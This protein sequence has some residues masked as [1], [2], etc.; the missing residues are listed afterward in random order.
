[1]CP[2][3]VIALALSF[4]CVFYAISTFPQEPAADELTLRVNAAFEA[5]KS[6]DA[7]AVS[8]ASRPVIA[9]TL[10]RMAKLRLD[11]KAYEEATKL[12]RDSLEFEDTALT[13]MEMAIASLYAKKPAEAVE[14]ATIATQM[15][16]RNA[17][18]WSIKGQA[19]LRKSDFEGASVALKTA[20]DLKRDSETLHALGIAYL[21]MREKE[22][23][24]ETFSQVLV[25]TGDAGWSRVLIGRAYQERKFPQDAV[26]QFKTALQLDPR[27]PN[28]HY[29]WAF[30]LLQAND[31]SPTPE[32]QAQL[33]EELHLNS[34]H[35]LA[36]YVLG[37]SESMERK[38]AESDR[39]LR[40][41]L[42]LSP[43]LPEIW[44]YLGLNAN[45]REER[46]SAERYFR[47]AISLREHDAHPGQ[48]LSVRKAYIVLGR[49]LLTTGRENEGNQLLQ[50]AR[51]MQL[52]DLTDRQEKV[53]TIKSKEGTGVSGAV[54]PDIS[55]AENQA[56]LSFAPASNQK[57][58]AS[59]AAAEKAEAQL[60]SLLGSSFNDLA[61][62]EALQEEFALALKHYLAA[63]TWD[64]H[65]PGL[66]RNLGLAYFATNDFAKSAKALAPFAGRAGQDPQLGFALA[67]SFA[68]TGNKLGAISVLQKMEATET[69]P[70]ALRSVEIGKLWQKLNQQD[71]AAKSFRRALVIDPRNAEANCA[72][73]L[74]A[75]SSAAQ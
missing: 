24:H 71:R 44:M 17:L 69:S 73:H 34:R 63:S 27:T 26:E 7:I 28:A 40:V 46:Q 67:K 23:A 3:F 32:V 50:K 25:L 66:Q 1:M 31:W 41:A 75:C 68:E 59:G 35:F 37:I 47:K 30:T 21:G 13:R 38:F 11:A 43:S 14:Q 49:I 72:L 39:Y 2:K 8:Q 65:I 60:R 6:E 53:A 4:F 55:E 5:R 48:H 70:D 33:L 54:V 36:N 52:E 45:A 9:L 62:A 42:E 58:H 56:P 10:V 29:Y 18:T 16:P 57:S 22:K 20:L 15:A 51:K 61:T 64:S 19:L 12:C 74:P